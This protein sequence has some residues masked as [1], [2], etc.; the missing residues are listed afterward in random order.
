MRNISHNLLPKDFTELGLFEVL[1]SRMEEINSVQNTRFFLFL[2][3]EEK[4]LSPIF[5]ISLYRIINELVGNI[6]KHS[7]ASEA[8]IEVMLDANEVE[9]IV[10]DNGI[11]MENAVDQKGIGLKNI[12]TRVDFLKGV[13]NIQS[14]PTGTHIVINIPIQDH[15]NGKA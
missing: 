5:S 9:L 1:E 13:M 7:Q 14:G 8:T 3:G 4:Q 10:G 11:G 15:G 12:R 2:N 6:L